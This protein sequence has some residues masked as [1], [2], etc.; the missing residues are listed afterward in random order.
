MQQKV[1][2][3]GNPILRRKS[4]FV[5]AEFIESVIVR[6]I[7]ARLIGTMRRIK[8]ISKDHGNGLSAPQIG[9]NYRII[10]LYFD[11]RYNV[12]INPKVVEK[13]KEIC[14]YGEGCL[15]FFY[16]R[17]LVRRNKKVKVVALNEKGERMRYTFLDRLASLALHEIDHLDGVLYLDKITDKRKIVSIDEKY[18]NQP[19]KLKTLRKII[20]YVTSG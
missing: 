15:S 20:A 11:N 2:Q 3:L 4:K 7:I 12:L 5:R 10:V 14:E 18:K 9:F 8:K 6:D 19:G 13:S 1:L 17:G 16:L